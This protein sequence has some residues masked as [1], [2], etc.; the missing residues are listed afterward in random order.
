MNAYFSANRMSDLEKEDILKQH[1]TLYDGYRTMQP[2]VNNEQPLYVQ[3]FAK[4]KVGVTLNNKGVAKPY[5]NVGI[6]EQVE[7]KEVCDECGS[8][9]MEGECMECG[10][11]GEVGAMEEEKGSMCSECGGAMNEGECM[12]CGYKMESLE[13][14][15]HLDDIYNVED[16]G[17][18]EFD[19]VEGGG[20]DYGTFEKMHHMKK[21]KNE[22]TEDDYEDPDNEDDGFEDLQAQGGEMYELSSKE[23]M[24]GKK[25][26]FKSP[27]FEDDVEFDDEFEDKAGGNSMFKFKGSK[28][29]HMIPSKGIEDYVTNIDEQGYTGGGNAPDMDISNIDP[30]YDFKSDGPEMGDEPYDEE[31][32]DMDL[33]MDKVGKAYDFQ[34]NGPDSV[35]PTEG[36]LDEEDDF[37]F[38]ESAFNDDEL[39]EANDISG[40]Q[41]IYGDMEP[42]FDFDSKG[43]GSAGPYQTS[44]WSEGETKEQF[45]RK[46]EYNKI[47]RKNDA[48]DKGEDFDDSELEMSDY[49]DYGDIKDKSWEEI[50]AITG[51]DEFGHVDED[52]RESLLQQ[53]NK[54]TEMFIRMKVIK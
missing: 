50:T 23:L 49:E 25:Y 10:W 11:K 33:D 5:T 7:S 14:T 9:M 32:E 31:A 39:E 44:S 53:K 16:L 46:H 41:G 20:N 17:D 26:K 54:I 8:L 22:Q 4:D 1:R 3:D 52:I 51:D 24:K 42:A 15:G 36:V 6:N 12:E 18:N 38:M 40:V 30:A 13:E 29:T 47:V 43:P 28:A 27:S 35:Y 45:P 21:I 34:S 48:L 19:Y 2:H 37:E